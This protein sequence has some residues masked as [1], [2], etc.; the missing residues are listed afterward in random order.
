MKTKLK[1]KLY[2]TI[3]VFSLC[4]NFSYAQWNWSSTPTWNRWG[5]TNNPFASQNKIKSIVVG[6]FLDFGAIPQS[7]LHVNANF[8][9]ST[10]GTYYYSRGEVF[11]TVGPANLDN[12]W[13][14]FTGAG[15]GTEKAVLFIPANSKDLVI[16]T[17]Q[18]FSN[19]RF[20]I[21]YNLQRVI[22]T[23]GKGQGHLGIGNNFS[24]P[25]HMLH[26]YTSPTVSNII[27]PAYAAFTNTNTDNTST[28]GFLVGINKDGV[29]QLNQ[30]ENKDMLFYTNAQE[31]VRIDTNGY[32]GIYPSASYPQRRLDVFDHDSVQLRLT[33][34]EGIYT[35]FH[36]V[37]E[38]YLLINPVDSMVGINLNPSNL[39]TQALDIYGNARI[40]QLPVADTIMNV[41]VADN[42]GVLHVDTAFAGGGADLDWNYT[43]SAPDMF[44]IPTG[45]IGIG[46][47]SPQSLLHLNQQGDTA[48]YT[49][50][51]NGS[52]DSSVTDGFLIGINEDGV[53]Q[54]NQQEDTL[55]DIFTNNI[56]RMR[57][58][59]TTDDNAR[60]G[61]GP[62]LTEPLTYLHLGDDAVLHAGHRNWMDVG[63]YMNGTSDNMYVGLRRISDDINDAIIN[64]GNNPSIQPSLVD[65][66]RFVFTA[67]TNIIGVNA[68]G[69]DGL[70]I[71]RMASD[72]NNGFVGIGDFY[73]INNDPLRTL[74]VYNPDIVPQFRITQD[75]DT[76]YTDFQTTDA[77]DLL[78]NPTDSMAG[79][80]LSISDPPTQAIDVNGGARIRQ[81]PVADTLMNVVVA[82]NDGVL[83]VDTAFAGGGADNDWEVSTSGN[84]VFT[85]ITGTTI[86]NLPTGNVAIGVN[87][88]DTTLYAKL[89]IYQDTILDVYPPDI[90]K[91]SIGLG[92]LNVYR[93]NFTIDSISHNSYGIISKV[94]GQSDTLNASLSKKPLKNIS[95][96]FQAKNAMTNYGIQAYAS[97]DSGITTN[98]INYGVYTIASDGDEEN[99]G[100]YAKVVADGSAG[101]YAIY[102]TIDDTTGY[103]YAGYFDGKV[104]STSYFYTPGWS[105]QSD[106][107]LKK[108]T[109]SF[110]YGLDIVKQIKPR[111]FKY[112]GKANLDT[113]KKYIGLIAQDLAQ[114]APYAVDTFYSKLDSADTVL[115]PLLA[116]KNEAIIYTAINAIKQLDSSVTVLEQT[117]PPNKPV[118][119][120]PADSA[121]DVLSNIT[122]IWHKSVR[123]TSYA[124]FGRKERI[125]DPTHAGGSVLDR[126]K[127][128]WDVTT[129]VTDTFIT[130]TLLDYCE[131]YSWYIVALNDAGAS[132]MSDIWSFTTITPE[133][134]EPPILSSPANASVDLP[135]ANT[136]I[137]NKAERTSEYQLYISADTGSISLVN[138]IDS[139]DTFAI[140]SVFDYNT[141]YY[142]WVVAYNCG[143]ESIKSEIWSFTT[144]S[145]SAAPP[146]TSEPLASDIA[147]KNNVIP[148]SDALSMT[149]DLNGI[150]FNW[151]L[152]NFPE[153]QD[154]GRQTGLIA[155]DVEQVIPEVVSTDVNGYLN[156][157]Y[158]RLVPVLIEAVKELKAQN[159]EQ[160]AQNDEQQEQLEALQS[161]VNTCCDSMSLKMLIN[162]HG[163]TIYEQG[164]AIN[165]ELQKTIHNIE[166]S[167][168]IVVLEQNRPN[169][170]KENTSIDYF[171]PE[172]VDFAQI[173]FYNNHGRVIKLVDIKEKG[174]GQL[175]VFAQNLTDGI[176]TYSIVFDGKLTET[177]KMVKAK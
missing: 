147:F 113:S 64:W 40:R 76:V 78:I 175:Q 12:A 67:P 167:S 169:P 142:W 44:A 103:N 10:T 15:Q 47:Q 61:I 31:H 158:S 121:T 37:R 46:I 107:L 70:E 127:E 126:E 23:D 43:S 56:R 98:K 26:I 63:V 125:E 49:Q 36:T 21:G 122:V 112:N 141:T 160:K 60:V 57:I 166:L 153:L 17:T 88:N 35:D 118:L 99:Y 29:A 32:V 129:I 20:K 85:G 104:Y 42:D 159:D 2:A 149:L 161:I 51:T 111:F 81:L 108:D 95:G 124:L 155:Q 128:W 93:S 66:L 144:A 170:F 86:P 109:S 24:N 62:N 134:P 72:G 58:W 53:A 6:N 69:N 130:F 19:I 156:V 139:R 28:D 136:F 154:T 119:I 145:D 92:I 173:I 172:D 176:Y 38:G 87:A 150:Y 96:S 18:P 171:I 65:R 120:S 148:I 77:G 5:Q 162:D 90:V 80:N 132:T 84:D 74:E 27:P 22:I 165:E 39:P 50:F 152:V 48:L 135:L 45:N 131:T 52:T 110:N 133:I 75:Y 1:M 82:D 151:D 137:W 89:N 100:I 140:A 16:Q 97:S 101:N 33:Y 9:A 54:L 41:V 91:K 30:Q 3:V 8:L 73:T 68:S 34:L 14:M 4:A 106:R 115:T 59:H 7:A 164:G 79:I 25:Q 94:I 116:V 123:A 13:R 71:A 168:N 143:G 102:A 174:K 11:R 177:K 114:F 146:E 105:S 163:Q 83:H 157:D 117:T 55:I 138:V